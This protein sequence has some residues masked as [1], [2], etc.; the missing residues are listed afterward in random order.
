[1]KIGII[2]ADILFRPRH[3]FPNLA[4][5]KMSGFF[6]K[7]GH[8]T[9]LV[10]GY[11]EIGKFDKLYLSQVFTDTCVPPKVLILGNLTYGGTGF[12]YDKAPKLPDE[13][14]HCMPDYG[15]YDA[16]IEKIRRYGE[17]DS[18]Y[19]F[20]TDYSIGFLTRGCFRQC[21]FCVNRNST[22]S[23]PASPLEEFMDEKRK[24]LCFLDD[25]FF[26]CPEWESLLDKVM[27]TGKRYQF[28]Q[29]LDLRIMQKKHIEKLFS[30]KL[31]DKVYFAFDDIRDKDLIIRKLDL[32]HE[33]V[34]VKM[35]YIRVYVLCGFDRV[36]KWGNGFWY[37]D[38]RD[39]LERVKILMS[40]GCFPYIMRYEKCWTSPYYGMYTVISRWCN[41]PAQ[42]KKKS[43]REFC[44]LQGGS[45]KRYLDEFE[46]EYPQ[47]SEYLD[48]K[49]DEVVADGALYRG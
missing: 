9:S 13:I 35:K 8:Q 47:I 16:Y 30:G 19:K 32:L 6:K 21:S 45:S 20:Y 37:Q 40:F 36:G 15:L 12:Y 33:T 28:R 3:R 44:N 10:Q 11:E 25:N 42:F 27:E 46:K 2:D 7:E 14:E 23:V 17:S 34:E 24:K 18:V 5:M 38:I 39:T 1:M 43:L 31:D 26:A 41:Q 22:R 49:Y 4:C 48:M 29:G